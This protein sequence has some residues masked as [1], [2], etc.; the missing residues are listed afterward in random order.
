V[1]AATDL[2]L[3]ALREASPSELDELRNWL[4]S[5]EP[6]PD[7]LSKSS[8]QAMLTTTEAARRLNCCTETILRQIRAGALSA[9]MAGSRYRIAVADLDELNARRGDAR[10]LPEH[11]RT[12]SPRSTPQHAMREAMERH[13]LA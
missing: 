11:A 3:T 4:R 12:Q 10:R 2:V 1:S 13:G 7:S 5:T 8:T 6:A 9:S